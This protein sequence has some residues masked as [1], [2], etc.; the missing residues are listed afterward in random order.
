MSARGGPVLYIRGAPGGGGIPGLIAPSG[1]IMVGGDKPPGGGGMPPTME[2][3]V[4][5]PAAAGARHALLAPSHCACGRS[6]A[7]S[8]VWTASKSTDLTIH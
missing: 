6:T 8:T 3:L 7:A 2:A 4:A 1:G 5:P